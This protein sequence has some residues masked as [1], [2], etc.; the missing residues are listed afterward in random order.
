MVG[1]ALHVV[2]QHRV[3]P[4]GSHPQIGK[5][6]ETVGDSFQVTSVAGIGVV[7][8][9]PIAGTHRD[10]VV[11]G[12]TLGKP[13]RHNQVE[14]IRWTETF[15]GHTLRIALF[16]LVVIRD[17]LLSFSKNDFELLRSTARNI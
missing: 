16:Q 12:V 5:V 4:D 10:M 1:T 13:V 11:R 14:H 6:A 3:K 15:H 2:L 8:V 7:A 9:H 17:F